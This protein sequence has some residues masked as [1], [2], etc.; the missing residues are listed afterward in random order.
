M[1]PSDS[2]AGGQTLFSLGTSRFASAT[3]LAALA[4]IAA[5]AAK[6][7]VVETFYLSGNFGSFFGPPVPF[8]G[9][10]NLDFSDNF[11][12]ET[13]QSISITVDGRPVF[14]LN[15]SLSLAIRPAKGSSTRPT[16]AAMCSL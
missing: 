9:A 14:N 5:P 4:L 13:V 2:L 6:A 15:P 12:E 10:I 1:K 7:D 11:A 16:A 3:V 8:T